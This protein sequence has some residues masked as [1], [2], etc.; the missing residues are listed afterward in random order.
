MNGIPYDN[1]LFIRT[2]K[3]SQFP[4]LFRIEN[5]SGVNFMELLQNNFGHEA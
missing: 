5:S 2:I 3:V 1:D 4:K